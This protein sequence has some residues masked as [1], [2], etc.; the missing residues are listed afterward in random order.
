MSLC[1]NNLDNPYQ[2]Q[3]RHAD[4]CPVGAQQANLFAC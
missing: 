3:E 4:Q 1:D 2:I